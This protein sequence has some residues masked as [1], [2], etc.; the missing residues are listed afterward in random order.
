MKT[1][2]FLTTFFLIISLT[3]MSQIKVFDDDWVTIGTIERYGH[4]IILDDYKVTYF[5][6]SKYDDYCPQEVSVTTNSLAKSWIV[7]LN[8][9][10]TFFVQGD[11]WVYAQGGPWSGCDS[12]FKK[13]IV[14]I[15]SPLNKVLQLHGIMY[16][17]KKKK[18]DSTSIE[19]ENVI[20]DGEPNMDNF[21][22]NNKIKPEVRKRLNE[23]KLQK[24]LGVIAQ[25]VEKISPE[26]VR[27][28]P[29]GTLAVEYNGI[30]ALLIEAI[31]EQQIMIETIS[32]RQGSLLNMNTDDGLK[33]TTNDES[34]TISENYLYQ[35]SPNPF[36]QNTVIRYKI[37][38]D[39]KEASM[40]IFN[41]QGELLKTYS[42]LNLKGE[43]II[44]GADFNPGIYLYSLIVNGTEIS[45]KRMILTNL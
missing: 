13:N 12:T 4:G 7:Q 23:E 6:P 36:N 24:H 16:N 37:K 29:D 25:E 26:L 33:M 34:N 20:N 19:S 28:M 11:G 18:N 21:K 43:L 17:C 39:A 41:I 44:K 5:T 22:D 45:T 14:E 30:I 15:G 35:N 2:T 32:S 10:H 31:K 3:G 1:Q 27:M 8:S 40:M 9:N 42:I 38:N